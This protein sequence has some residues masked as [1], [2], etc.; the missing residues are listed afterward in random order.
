MFRRVLLCVLMA[1]VIVF[2]GFTNKKSV[3]PIANVNSKQPDKV[4]YDRA[5]DA[6][7]HNKFDVARLSLQ[8]LINTYPDSEYV[9]RAKLA[10][11]DSW[12]AEGGSAA[13]AQAESEY[14]DFITFFPNMTEASEAQMKIANIHYNEMEKP[15]RDYTHA[16]RAEEEYRQLIMQFPDSPL[17]PEA[18][19]RLLSVQEVLAER[20]FMIAHFYYLRESWPASIARL[21]SL[22]DTY[23]LY[24]GSDEAL[25]E[26]GGAYEKEADL[27][28]RS[29]FNEAAKAPLI[30]TYTD[31]AAAAYDRI[32][33]RYPEEDRV[34]DARKRLEAMGKPIPKATPE[35][36][37]QNKKEI[38]SRGSLSTIGKVMENF[39]KAP[40][41]SDAVKVGEPT[42]VDPKQASAPEFVRSATA[43]VV[44]ALNASTN[45]TATA[46][47][48][49]G[50]A[51]PPENGADAPRSD[52]PAAPNA[53]PSSRANSGTSVS[54][55]IE[56][57]KSS[58]AP[59][60]DTGGIQI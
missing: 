49:T 54:S 26:L 33:T 48:G 35:A 57:I 59:N 6:M 27:V 41:V 45:S 36:I 25:Y 11:G 55:A 15:D 14:K 4:L 53:R 1:S 42:L 47:P 2:V 38:E 46:Q 44:S 24:S 58:P 51:P 17:V 56:V 7:K 22:T 28:R 16:K 20:E 13:M 9:A 50:T 29:K 23:P 10:I 31:S 3:N 18:K 37:A 52:T 5:M 32:L 21:K 40:D 60:T 8:T 12:Y 34:A 30:K 43:S 19:K 39:K